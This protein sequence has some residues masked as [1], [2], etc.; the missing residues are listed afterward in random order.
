MPGLPLFVWSA[1]VDTPI[2]LP[3][4]VLP[5]A[6]RRSRSRIFTAGHS[7]ACTGGHWSGRAIEADGPAEFRK[8]VRTQIKHGADL[9]KLMLTG[10]VA[11]EHEGMDTAQLADEELRAVTEVAHQWGRKVTAHAGPAESIRRAIDAGL[12]GVEHGYAL[13]DEVV[14]LMV[15]VGTWYVP[16]IVVTPRRVL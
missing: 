5:S 3:L 16:T 15:A 2:R 6:E 1:N 14:A 13:N 7:I 4:F 11:G 9:I 12:D 8:A 10:G